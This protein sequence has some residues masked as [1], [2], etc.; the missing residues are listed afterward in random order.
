MQ[1]I[2]FFASV[3]FLVGIGMTS[4]TQGQ[5]MGRPGQMADQPLGASPF[6]VNSDTAVF[7]PGNLDYDMQPFAPLDISGFEGPT[8]VRGGFFAAYGRTFLSVSRPNPFGTVNREA[9]PNGADFQ[10]GNKFNFGN[11]SE[12]GSGWDVTYG[13]TSGLFFS[14]GGSAQIA[15][16]MMTETQLHG[17]A[18][19]RSFRQAL[20]KG[21][22]IEPY[23]GLRYTY[24]SDKTIQDAETSFLD[25]GG[26]PDPDDDEILAGI[27]R[28]QQQARNSIVGGGVGFRLYQAR[29]R[30]QWKTDVGL[31]GGY[32]SQ[33]Y[34]ESDE[35][36]VSA[37][38]DAAA[39]LFGIV[40]RNRSDSFFTPQLDV[41][42]ELIYGITR[43]ISLRAGAQMTY[44]WGGLN[45]ANT[46]EA[47][48]NP[49]SVAG[50][51]I[52]S[53]AIAQQSATVAGFLLGVEW[54]R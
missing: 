49:H 32:N 13:K 41:G 31:S 18:L 25:D 15:L 36:H 39:S 51:G 37:T 43:D 6:T 26:T 2:R 3:A 45:R 1:I 9:F 19:N 47:E 5:I 46:L 24:F 42:A 17:F 12:D 23:F 44:F 38:D 8:P 28:F 30:W 53:V 34:N 27:D 21:G 14:R 54:R 50:P 52:G 4:V 40:E 11:M 33:T 7:D 20:S 10:S 35:L 48:L 22:F 16:P 29:G